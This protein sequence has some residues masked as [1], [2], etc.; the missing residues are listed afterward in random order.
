M[1]T[2]LRWQE[3]LIAN[4]YRKKI[5]GPEL[6]LNYI[7]LQPSIEMHSTIYLYQRKRLLCYISTLL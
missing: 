4:A 1:E 2:F 5:L 7:A 6:L 3:Q